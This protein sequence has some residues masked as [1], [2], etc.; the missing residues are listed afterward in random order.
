MSV[1]A[2]MSPA[3][4]RIFSLLASRKWIIREG[5]NGISRSGS[6]APMARGVKKS[7]GL[8]TSGISL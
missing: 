6:G 2:A 5:G 1:F 7:R 8:R 4:A 3:F